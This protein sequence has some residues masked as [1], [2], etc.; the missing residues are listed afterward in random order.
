MEPGVGCR[1]LT[2]VE[3]NGRQVTLHGGRARS[4]AGRLGAC[5]PEP[6]AEGEA[7]TPLQPGHPSDGRE[8]GPSRADGGRRWWA[9]DEPDGQASEPMERQG[10]PGG[11]RLADA[12]A[13]RGSPARARLALAAEPRRRRA[14]VS[15]A[16]RLGRTPRSRRVTWPGRFLRPARVLLSCVR[17]PQQAAVLVF[18]APGQGA[19]LGAYGS[20]TCRCEVK[21]AAGQG[22]TR[23]PRNPVHAPL[24]SRECV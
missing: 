15:V 12:D 2:R 5:Q 17:W 20:P 1:R 10:P 22:D 11:R 19:D 13:R 6:A 14:W 21:P 3:Q 8:A 16:R 23:F 7:Y 18:A 24:S 4:R 9:G